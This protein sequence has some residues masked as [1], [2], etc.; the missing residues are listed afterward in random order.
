MELGKVFVDS[1]IVG[2]RHRALDSS[3]VEALAESMKTL[4]LQQPIGVYVDSEDAAYLVTG[5][6]RLEAARKLGWEEI[7][8]SFLKLSPLER[9]MWE[10][11]ENLH[12]I[13]LTKEERDAHIR[14]YV[15]LLREQETVI[16]CQNDKQSAKPVGRP[17]SITTKVAEETGLNQQTVRRALNPAP[18]PPP[19]PRAPFKQ[20]VD[21]PG[22]PNMVEV[23]QRL[24]NRYTVGQLQE[25]ID[26]LTDVIM[27]RME[28]A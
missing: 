3:K 10:I 16:V 25:I 5:R 4:G 12:R 11:S 20:T 6:H 17:K 9:E 1:V 14:R 13:G 23:A 8:A 15:E 21:D 28:A 19:A 27:S 26:H 7:D 2:S 18:K 22:E 24:A